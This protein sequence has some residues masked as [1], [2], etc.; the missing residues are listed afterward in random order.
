MMTATTT[1]GRHKKP[2]LIQ[3][4]LFEA[5]RCPVI[6]PGVA[7][8]RR[9]GPSKLRAFK[10]L[11]AIWTHRADG[12]AKKDWPWTAMLLPTETRQIPYTKG[13]TDPWE[14]LNYAGMWMD[15]AG[16]LVHGRTEWEALRLLCKA[17][18]IPF[19]L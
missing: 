2:R 13:S 1:R 12:W 16:L 17:N 8:V 11:H 15:D 5:P 9:A 18:D 3:Q 7:H 4:E 14:I 19:T 6:P 10:T